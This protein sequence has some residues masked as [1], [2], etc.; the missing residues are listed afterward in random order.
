[1]GIVRATLQDLAK[2]LGVGEHQLD[3]MH[4]EKSAKAAL[5]RRGLFKAVGAVTAGT[6]FAEF[7]HPGY[8]I[9]NPKLITGAFSEVVV[10]INGDTYAR[11]SEIRYELNTPDGIPVALG[12]SVGKA[13]KRPLSEV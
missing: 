3:V 2:L 11:W 7:Q 13:L 1:M 5:S 8:Y 12:R 6:L 10:F 9:T 4:E